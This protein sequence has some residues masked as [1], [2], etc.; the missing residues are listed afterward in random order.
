MHSSYGHNVGYVGAA[1]HAGP[2]R[3]AAC[4][5]HYQQPAQMQMIP[6]PS[7]MTVGPPPS[8]W[9]QVALQQPYMSH[10]NTVIVNQPAGA[11][12]ATGKVDIRDKDVRD[13][14]TGLCGCFENFGVCLAGFCCMPCFMSYLASRMHESCWGPLCCHCHFMIALRTRLRSVNGIKGKVC[15]DVFTMCCCPCCAST[16]MYRELKNSNMI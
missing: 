16:Q 7:S 6:A 4:A 2:S 14:T 12:S 13:W 15:K 1:G 8:A 9:G 11:A 3:C 5:L 10:Q